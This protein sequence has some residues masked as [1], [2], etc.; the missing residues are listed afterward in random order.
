M[1]A[2]L[3]AVVPLS[4]ADS[5]AGTFTDLSE[6]CQAAL[7]STDAS[8]LAIPPLRPFIAWLNR[9]FEG[10]KDGI[11]NCCGLLREFEWRTQADVAR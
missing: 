1:L 10:R 4:S 11:R 3:A 9:I 5:I 6:R 7:D 2:A 8:I